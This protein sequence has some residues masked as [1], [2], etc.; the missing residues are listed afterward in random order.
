MIGQT[1]K[2]ST[3][4]IDDNKLLD[5]DGEHKKY[6]DYDRHGPWLWKCKSINSVVT[7]FVG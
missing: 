7:F 2:I 5:N 6:I 1:F 3:A 4:A